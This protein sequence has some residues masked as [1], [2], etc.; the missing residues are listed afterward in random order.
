M[1]NT[2]T[3]T[4]SNNKIIVG[5]RVSGQRHLSDPIPGYEE[6]EL[7]QQQRQQ[8]VSGPSNE[9]HSQDPDLFSILNSMHLNNQLTAAAAVSCL[10]RGSRLLRLSSQ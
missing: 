1:A 8:H 7:L 6:Q 4:S 10:E 9:Q 2:D 3:T 5:R